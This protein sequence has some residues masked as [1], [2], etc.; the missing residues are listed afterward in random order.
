[1][2]ERLYM[3]V[4]TND[5][6]GAMFGPFESAEEAEKQSKMLGWHWVLIYIRTVENGKVVGVETRFY[7]LDNFGTD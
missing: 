3:A 4:D 6:K 7:Q 1:M 2:I 5:E